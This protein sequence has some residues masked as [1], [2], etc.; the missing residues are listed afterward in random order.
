MRSDRAWELVVVDNASRDETRSVIEA[1]ERELPVPLIMVSEP[2]PGVTRARNSGWHAAS[3]AIV[4]FTDDDCY[5]APDLIS[6]VLDRFDQEDGLG[7]L[8]GAVLPH[9][10]TDARVAFVAGSEPIE[11]QP[12][13]FVTPGLV[14]SANLAFRRSALEAIDGFDPFFEYTLG[15]AGEDVDAAA[16]VSGA[17]WIGR[18]DPSAVVYHHHGRKRGAELDRVRSAYDLGRGAFFAKC[19]CDA[20]LRRTYLAG[21]MRLTARRIR[22]RQGIRAIGRELRGAGGYLAHRLRSRGRLPL[23]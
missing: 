14:L 18:Y 8:A 21:W 12:A 22:R 1:A 4:A 7:F 5:P 23:L 11:I 19:A 10:P 6:V 2:V 15:W 3:G 17:G 16:R 13:G 9:D 20:R